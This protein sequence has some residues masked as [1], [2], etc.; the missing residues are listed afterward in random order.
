MSCYG[1][2]DVRV[3]QNPPRLLDMSLVSTLLGGLMV[4]SGWLEAISSQLK[5]RRQRRGSGPRRSATM[6]SRAV[7]RV[8]AAAT[9]AQ[10]DQAIRPGTAVWLHD[11][12]A[13][14]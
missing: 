4:A 14:V 1:C 5:D 13:R 9:M 10:V 2:H 8:A 6:N 3:S 11:H 7:Q 12:A